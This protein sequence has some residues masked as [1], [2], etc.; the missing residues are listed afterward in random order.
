MYS[1]ENEYVAF[2]NGTGE[3]TVFTAKGEVELW[4]CDLELMMR[5]SL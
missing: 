4:L 1:K 3:M 5:V 2:D